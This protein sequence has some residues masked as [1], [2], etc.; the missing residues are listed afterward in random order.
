M[1]LTSQKGYT[2]QASVPVCELCQST[3][4]ELTSMGRR[5]GTLNILESGV[6]WAICCGDEWACAETIVR[7]RRKTESRRLNQLEEMER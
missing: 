4:L 5:L 6:A 3:A 2:L 1:S 7:I